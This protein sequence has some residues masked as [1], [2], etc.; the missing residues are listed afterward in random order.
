MNLNSVT[1]KPVFLIQD[2]TDQ[3]LA[4]SDNENTEKYF[5]FFQ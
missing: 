3:H 2:V 1:F 4:R 5:N